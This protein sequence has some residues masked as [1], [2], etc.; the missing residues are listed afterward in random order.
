M[1]DFAM[2]RSKNL[3]LLGYIF[4]GSSNIPVMNFSLMVSAYKSGTIQD[5]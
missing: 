3:F 4:T 2:G 1:L 5:F